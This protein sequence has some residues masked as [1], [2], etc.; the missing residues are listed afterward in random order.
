[1]EFIKKYYR[2]GACKTNKKAH[3]KKTAIYLGQVI[4][5]L[6]LVNKNFKYDVY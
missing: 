2:K 1:M 3:I 4:K 5:I 6:I